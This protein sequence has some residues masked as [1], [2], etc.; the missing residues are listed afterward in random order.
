M[1]T[2]LATLSCLTLLAPAAQAQSTAPQPPAEAAPAAN[3]QDVGSADAIIASLYD[4]ISGD[5]GV[6]RDWARFRSLFFH[7][8]HMI[9]TGKNKAGERIARVITVDDYVGRAAMLEAAGFH[10]KEL[11]RRTEVFGSIWHVFSTYETQH[12]VEGKPRTDR[13]INSI[14]L[15]HDGKRWWILN[16]AWDQ[17]TSER[18]IPG[19]YL[20]N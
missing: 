7:G 6:K 18:P 17:E 3:P 13:G 14:Q 9:P 11:A 1:R 4:V 10:E 2:L 16:I 5:K 19:K 15:F 20:K 8:A 12:E